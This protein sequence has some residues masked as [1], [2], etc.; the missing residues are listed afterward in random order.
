MNHAGKLI[1]QVTASCNVNTLLYYLQKLPVIGKKVPDSV[2]ADPGLKKKLQGVVTVLNLLKKIVSKALYLLTVIALPA[3][4]M[5]KKPDAAPISDLMIHE[6][7]FLSALFG[8]LADSMIFTVTRPKIMCLKY[9]KMEPGSFVRSALFSAYFPHFALYL[10]MLLVLFSLFGNGSGTGL[11][12]A[13]AVWFLLLCFRFLGE[14]LQL[15][16]FD[17]TGIILSRKNGFEIPFMLLCAAAA[18][19]PMFVR[20]LPPVSG[21]VLNPAFL[22]ASGILG[23]AAFYYVVRG[24]LGYGEK[25]IRTLDTSFLFSEAVKQS[26]TSTFSD[27]AVREE[28]LTIGSGAGHDNLKGYALLNTL[29]FERHRRQLMKPAKLRS[30]IAFCLFPAGALLYMLKPE[31]AVS[32]ANYLPTLLPS[33]VFVMYFLSVADKACRAMF[34]N[35]DSSL[36]R[37]GFYRRPKSILDNFRCRLIKVC[38]YNL[39]PAGVLCFSAVLFRILCKVPVFTLDMAVF[40]VSILLLGIFFG[41]HHLFMYYVFQPYTTEL[42]VKNPFFSVI[43]TVVYALCFLC[44][45]IETA[46]TSFALGLLLFTCLYIAAAL[47]LVYRF[48]PK[49]FRVK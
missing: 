4:L 8:A 20:K 40:L 37:F 23:A 18:Y 36:L 6:L 33:F 46:G 39:A 49:T 3:I 22:A 1:F 12:E 38:G 48:A 26:K 34:Y 5:A 25:L 21:T 41:V 15:L 32:L 7:F 13:A 43:N 24:Y 14:A 42:N 30:A 29:F 35:C 11:R 10:P 9:L 27:V 28:D 47:L 19:L 17:K 2:Y 16:L 45:Q 44:M 31:T